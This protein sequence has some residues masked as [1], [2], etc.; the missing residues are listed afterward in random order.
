MIFFR[1]TRFLERQN[2]ILQGRIE[3]LEARNQEL[4]IKMFSKPGSTPFS[5]E[6]PTPKHHMTKSSNRASCSCGWIHVSEDPGELQNAIASHFRED[7]SI[8]RGRRSWPQ[9]K[10]ALERASEGETK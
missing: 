4:I 2:E 9:A 5:E 8:Q 7:I 6:K 1:Y 3:S 10:A